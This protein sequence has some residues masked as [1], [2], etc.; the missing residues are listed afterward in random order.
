MPG[1][2]ARLEVQKTY[3]LFIGGKFVRGENGRV[4]PARERGRALLANY[5][6]V[7]KKD[8]R[9]QNEITRSDGNTKS[10]SSLETTRA[11]DRLVHFSRFDGQTA[12]K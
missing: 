11:I 5:C 1:K 10:A 4:L 2:P 12:Y 7:S 6:R 9:E 3:K 8:F